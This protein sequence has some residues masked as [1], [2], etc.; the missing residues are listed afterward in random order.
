M[1]KFIAFLLLLAC[2]VVAEAARESDIRRALGELATSAEQQDGITIQDLLEGPPEL[3]TSLPLFKQLVREDRRELLLQIGE[4][5]LFEDGSVP[6]NATHAE[7]FLQASAGHGSSQAQF[8]LG[9]LRAASDDSADAQLYYAF[10]TRGQS[11]GASMALGYRALHGYGS[12]KSCTAAMR[13]YKF[14]ADR[15]V[16]QQN[17]Q[18]LQLYAFPEPARLSETEGARYHGDLNPAEDFNRAEY[19]RQRAADLRNTDVMVQSASITLFSDLYGVTAMSDLEEHAA[20]EREALRF[21]ER[22][23]EMGSIKAQALLGHV[24]AYGLAGCKSNASRAV[25]LYEAALNASEGNP[26]GEAANGLGVIFSR[27]I[28]DMPVDPDRARDLFKVAANAGHAEGVYNTGMSFLE[29]GS[30]L[31]SRAKEYFVAAAHVGHLKSLF[32]LARLKQRQIHTIG[33]ATTSSTSCQE[34]VE[35]YKRVAE[36]SREGTTL[37]TQALTHAQRGNW[38]LALELYLI[39]AEMG[40][41]VAQNNAVWLIERVQRQVFGTPSIRDSKLLERLY[42]RLVNRAFEQDSIDALL[43]MGDS[44]Y[45]DEDYTVALRHYQH[46]DL[47]SAGT[48]ARALF[49]VGYM[50]EHGLGV[51]FISPER[52]T[53]YYHLAGEKEPSLRI[54]MVLLQFKLRVQTMFSQ[55][56][57]TV[58]CVWL[59]ITQRSDEATASTEDIS[60]SRMAQGV[61]EGPALTSSD[62]SALD[63]HG[64]AFQQQTN[65]LADSAALVRAATRSDPHEYAV[66]LQFLGDQSRVYLELAR[67]D[68]PLEQQDFTIETWLRVDEFSARNDEQQV[69]TLVDALDNFQLELLPATGTADDCWM[70]RFRKFSL[71]DKQ[72]PELVLSFPNAPL[73]PHT[74]NH[75]AVTFDATYQTATLVLNAKVKQVLSFRPHPASPSRKEESSNDGSSSSQFLAVGSSLGRIYGMSPPNSRAFSG[76]IVHFRLWK[77]RKNV[78]EVSV[79][80]LEQYDEVGTRGLLV[81]LRYK[82]HGAS[83]SSSTH[84][85][86]SGRSNSNQATNRVMNGD[87]TIPNAEGVQL[88]IVEFPPPNN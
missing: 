86:N 49:S 62:V 63:T 12:R 48:S 14:A 8:L 58:R 69:I 16:T 36:Y 31:S 64:S 29:L 35:L 61:E 9:A 60:S 10:A 20:R 42:A 3:T 68:L 33:G 15:V 80:M 84:S 30:H 37:M 2:W 50:H 28:G 18:K 56:A 78:K 24:Y 21:L 11:I 6:H 70:L 72:L 66:A 22:S 40:Y 5:H 45:Q 52:A 19:L 85:A 53:L 25:E 75:V 82:L 81:H 55:V 39:A 26:S 43:R 59:T 47:V 79:L 4:L 77:S 46:A 51:S 13:H 7:L 67:G 83:A 76:Q 27:G 71:V 17:D 38:A 44:A 34:V 1:V 65:T 73:S 87:R 32:Q 41:E 88:K 57:E 54:V 74:W 23:I